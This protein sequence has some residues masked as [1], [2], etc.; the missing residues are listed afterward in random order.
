MTVEPRRVGITLA[1]G[2]CDLGGWGV[3]ITSAEGLHDSGRRAVPLLNYNLTFATEE[4]H[5]KPQSV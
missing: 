1:D 3:E 2:P 5:G 4:K